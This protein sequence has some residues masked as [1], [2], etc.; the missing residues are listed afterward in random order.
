MSLGVIKFS[1][2]NQRP[3][4]SRD[5][6]Y[7]NNSRMFDDFNLLILTVVSLFLVCFLKLDDIAVEQILDYRF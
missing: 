7:E 3:Q 4:P 2:P 6:F 5:V 1:S